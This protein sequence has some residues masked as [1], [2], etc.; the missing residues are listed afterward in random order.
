MN[1]KCSL[2][3]LLSVLALLALLLPQPEEYPRELSREVALQR[4]ASIAE[5][6]SAK[7][8]NVRL[9]S[10]AEILRAVSKIGSK[11]YLNNLAERK[12][13]QVQPPVGDKKH[14]LDLPQPD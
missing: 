12:G 6:A 4:L 14:L 7:S 2:L 11:A 9:L 10:Y 1:G 5:A 3:F 13:H 8:K